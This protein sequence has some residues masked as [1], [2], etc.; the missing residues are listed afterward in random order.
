MKRCLFFLGCF[1]LVFAEP[2]PRREVLATPKKNTP[3]M[4]EGYN[5][6]ARIDVR[7]SWNIFFRGGAIYQIA[8][9]RGLD[10]VI[11]DATTNSSSVY[12]KKL[13]PEYKFKL[14]FNGAFGFFSDFDN[15]DCVAEYTRYH[16][17]T[18]TSVQALSTGALIMRW[19]P[20]S[21]RAIAARSAWSLKWDQVD[22][23]MGRA[24]FVGKEVL[25]R[26]FFGPRLIWGRQ[27]YNV[28][29]NISSLGGREK[30]SKNRSKYRSI[31]PR[32]GLCS[33]WRLVKWLSLEG[34][35]ASSIIYERNQVHSEIEDTTSIASV[36]SFDVKT[37]YRELKPQL[38][39]RMG[40]HCGTYFSHYRWH[41][42]LL[43]DYTFQVFWEENKLRALVD[44]LIS[45][46]GSSPGTLTMHGG[47]VSLQFSF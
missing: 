20:S 7:S 11:S 8:K 10:F 4:V 47:N 35:I 44:E 5:A 34:K 21:P 45:Q 38:D 33:T 28:Y 46:T 24:F 39:M 17:H 19:F 6:P 42:K 12:G 30:S 41:L 14:G 1:S 31:G 32:L 23:E 40:L 43:L 18:S 26:P 2:L 27:G 22:T 37:I 29:A 9:E 3:P 16:P 13:E 25:L 15:W 36:K